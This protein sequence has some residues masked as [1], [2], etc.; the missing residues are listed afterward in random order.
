MLKSLALLVLF[1]LPLRGQPPAE[2]DPQRVKLPNGWALTPAGKSL[3]LG[4]FP[5][6]MTFSPDGKYLAVTNDGQG[7]QSLQL[8]DA[9]RG[10]LADTRE[11]E[12]AW[13]GLAWSADG[14]R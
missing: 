3:T 6:N 11:V 13:L 8:V 4:D 14:K 7:I 9:S 1:T 2:S 5:L 12:S 10:V